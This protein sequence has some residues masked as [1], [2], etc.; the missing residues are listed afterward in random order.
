MSYTPDYCPYGCGDRNMRPTWQARAE[1]SEVRVAEL[2]TALERYCHALRNIVGILD[3][4]GDTP[5]TEM[6]AYIEDLARNPE[7]SEAIDDHLKRF[8]VKGKS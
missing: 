2:E 5:P 1:Q 7:R 3:K 4:S 6:L 8:R